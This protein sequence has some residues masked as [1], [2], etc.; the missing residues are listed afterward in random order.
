MQCEIQ[1][2]NWPGLPVSS[3]V[4]HEHDA[5]V[6]VEEEDGGAKVA[7]D[8]ADGDGAAG[9]VGDADGETEAEQEV[10]G[11]QVLQV[12]HHAAGRLLLSSAEVKL[13]D[14][15]VEEETQLERKQGEIYNYLQQL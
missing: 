7:V 2:S 1:T 8:Q 15:A 6:H 13:H 3:D 4:A 12:D 5:G 9:V 10:G 11:C 14:E